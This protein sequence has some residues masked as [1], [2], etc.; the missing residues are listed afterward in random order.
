MAAGDSLSAEMGE[1]ER[2][3]R[4][5]DGRFTYRRGRFYFFSRG[6]F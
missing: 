4:A 3:A 2:S 1:G 5:K 6:G